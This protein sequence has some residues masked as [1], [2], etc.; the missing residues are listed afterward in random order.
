MIIAECECLQKKM[1]IDICLG[2][3]VND[4]LYVLATLPC[5]PLD[6]VKLQRKLKIPQKYNYILLQK[7]PICENFSVCYDKKV[8]TRKHLKYI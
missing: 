8:L 2:G 5:Y 1:K 4:P 7:Y 6:G 3:V